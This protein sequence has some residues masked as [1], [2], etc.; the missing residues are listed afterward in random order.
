M[1]SYT[2]DHDKELNNH[3]HY[4]KDPEKTPMN[5]RRVRPV[6]SPKK[7][8]YHY[9]SLNDKKDLEF[10]FIQGITDPT[11]YPVEDHD[12]YGQLG[13]IQGFYDAQKYPYHWPLKHDLNTTT[14]LRFND[15]S[16]QKTPLDT[17]ED[18]EPNLSRVAY[19]N[20]EANLWSIQDFSETSARRILEKTHRIE[21][22]PDR[23]IQAQKLINMQKMKGKLLDPKAIHHPVDR[24]V[25]YE[26][27]L[28]DTN[29]MLLNRM[30][31]ILDFQEKLY[32]FQKFET[33]PKGLNFYTELTLTAGSAATK[34]NFQDDR[35]NKNV[36]QGTA[37][38]RY[39]YHNLRS[40]NIMFVSGT[41]LYYSTNEPD[42][43]L[44]AYIKFNPPAFPTSITLD[45]GAF[46]IWSLNLRADGGN[47]V[48]RLLGL[49]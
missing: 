26:E 27:M 45:Y 49:Y 20:K 18:S 21:N 23:K 33:R 42:S 1:S 39:P 11:G 13:L 9:A 3:H 46:D 37:M 7:I 14:A 47:A 30:T 6:N 38:Y 25:S 40:L 19:D 2:R 4:S 43:Q 8:D 5:K 24:L 15:M 28:L 17:S 12:Y 36:P 32:T 35:Y 29:I 16:Y 44:D 31:D 10:N 34:L 22:D 41:N 48:V